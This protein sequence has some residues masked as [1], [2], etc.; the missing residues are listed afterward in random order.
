MADDLQRRIAQLNETLAPASRIAAALGPVNASQLGVVIN[1][2]RQALV[3]ALMPLPEI[4]EPPPEETHT[5]GGELVPGQ[6]APRFTQEQGDAWIEPET[7]A[8]PDEPSVFDPAPPLG[9]PTP[10]Y[11][12]EPPVAEVVP[13]P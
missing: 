9:A 7:V 5:P 13:D 10:T 4:V 6:S 11:A 12:A 8:E 1:C 3:N 2:F